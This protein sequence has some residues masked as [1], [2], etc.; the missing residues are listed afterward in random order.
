MSARGTHD[1]GAKRRWS[2]PT[3]R[4]WEVLRLLNSNPGLSI[5]EVADALK[6]RKSRGAAIYVTVRRAIRRGFITTKLGKKAK[7]YALFA[8]PDWRVSP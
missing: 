2:R 5:A 4:Q 3:P 7:S 1:P 6:L 8:A